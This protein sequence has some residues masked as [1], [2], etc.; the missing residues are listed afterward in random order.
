M[1]KDKDYTVL[2][3]TILILLFCINLYLNDIRTLL[4]GGKI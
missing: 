2:L 3:W 1:K 4:M